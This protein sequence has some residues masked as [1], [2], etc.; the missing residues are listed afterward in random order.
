M[1][2]LTKTRCVQCEKNNDLHVQN[3]TDDEH[4]E[5]VEHVENVKIV[6]GVAQDEKF[7]KC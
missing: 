4:D 3:F 6:G 7:I 5:Y 2:L 1:C